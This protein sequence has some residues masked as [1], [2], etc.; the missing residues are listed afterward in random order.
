MNSE[1][2]D[3]GSTGGVPTTPPPAP[4]KLG[5]APEAPSG[6]TSS[7]PRRRPGKGAAIAIAAFGGVVLLGAGGNAAFAA[8]HDVAA[9]SNTGRGE[10]QTVSAAGLESLTVDVAAS[11]VTLRFGDVDEATLVV[12]GDRSRNWTLER[13]DDELVVRSPERS[14]GWWFGGDWFGGDWFGDD[15]KAVLTLP[16]SL[17]GGRLDADFALSAG[18]LDIEGV[19]GEVDLDVGAGA[20]R[21][22]G[23]ATSVDAD[24]SAGRA[25]LA[26]QN[27]SEADFRVAAGKLVA[28]LTDAAPSSV[29]ID[30]SAGSLDLTLPDETYDLSQDVSAGDLENRLDTSNDS[31][32]KIVA[33]VSAGEVVLRSRD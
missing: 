31:R 27:V 13:D 2:H 25:D 3:Q 19:Y 7:G 6:P 8:A 29:M 33:S 11:E 4:Q 21:M 10:T 30:V 26:L 5:S 15:E 17:D 24:V 9:A 20:L 23:A 16:D 32:F 28:T 22:D 1:T 18:S 12:T 14:F